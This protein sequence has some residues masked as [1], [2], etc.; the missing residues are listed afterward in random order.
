MLIFQND[1]NLKFFIK[2]KIVKNK[3]RL[4][5]GSGVNIHLHSLEKYPEEDHTIRFLFIGRMMKAKG[6]DE[7]LQAASIIKRKFPNTQFDLVGGCEEDYQHQLKDLQ[8][9]NV[10]TYHT[11]NKKSILLLRNHMLPFYLPIMKEQRMYSL[12]QHQLVVPFSPRE[13]RVVKK[14]LMRKSQV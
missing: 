11:N 13:F 9:L 10:I 1:N 14:P 12:N 2:N 6:V 3:T 5:P 7:L 8:S 4:V